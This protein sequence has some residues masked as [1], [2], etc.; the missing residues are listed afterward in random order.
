MCVCRFCFCGALNCYDTIC[1]SAR[2]LLAALQDAPPVFQMHHFL[3]TELYA[4]FE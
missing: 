2:I 4:D 1:S 3:G